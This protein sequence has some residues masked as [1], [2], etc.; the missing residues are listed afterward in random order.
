MLY[1]KEKEKRGFLEMMKEGPVM[2]PCVYDCVSALYVQKTGF[3]AM[4]L[5]GGELAG[6]LC[7]FPDIGLVNQEDVYVKGLGKGKPDG[8]GE[9]SLI[10]FAGEFA[11]LRPDD[12]PAHRHRPLPFTVSSSRR[13]P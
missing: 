9:G 4:C 5:S 7:G 11:A 10:E 6:S 8:V 2:A 3:K 13:V 1:E 12:D